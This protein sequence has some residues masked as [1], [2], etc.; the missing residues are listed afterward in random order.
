MESDIVPRSEERNRRGVCRRISGEVC[1]PQ[2][3]VHLLADT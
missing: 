3:I 1:G 2:I